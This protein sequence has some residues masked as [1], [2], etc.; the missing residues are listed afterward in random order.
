LR[1]LGFW[2]PASI[3]VEEEIRAVLDKSPY[4]IEL[5]EKILYVVS[6]DGASPRKILL[7]DPNMDGF[8]FTWSPDGT[9]WLAPRCLLKEKWSVELSI[10]TLAISQPFPDRMA[11]SS[12]AG[13]RTVDRS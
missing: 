7:E 10:S 1:S 2:S 3:R 5:Y 6:S 12:H 11:W 13:R 4:Q 8:D 9:R